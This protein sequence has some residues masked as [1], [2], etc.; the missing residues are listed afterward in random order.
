MIEPHSSTL[1]QLLRTLPQRGR[2]TWIGVRPARGAAPIAVASAE[3][4][5]GA[6]LTGDR[7]KGTVTSKRQVT[8][9]QAEHLAAVASLTGRDR[10]DPALTRRNVVVSGI[11]LYAL[12]HARFQAGGVLLE[13]TGICAPCAQ[14]E[15]A[16]GAGG[17]NAMRGH[18]GITAR[19]LEAGVI[20]IGDEV[21]LVEAA[22]LGP[23]ED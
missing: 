11:N 5:P 22:G 6:G 9:I 1:D 12:R 2:V 13:G 7:F 14:M 8:L 16:L 15:A 17:F 10:V 21:A 3:A 19:V 4:R 18:G 20:R 23:E